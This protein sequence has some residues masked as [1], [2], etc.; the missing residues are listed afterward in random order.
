MI[1]IIGSYNQKSENSGLKQM[2]KTDAIMGLKARIGASHL[3]QSE[4]M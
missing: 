1:E 3:N 4:Q 2:K